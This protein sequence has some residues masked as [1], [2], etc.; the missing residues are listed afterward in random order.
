MLQMIFLVVLVVLLIQSHVRATV[1]SEQLL[2]FKE[3]ESLLLLKLQKVERHSLQLHETISKRLRRAGIIES[4]SEENIE[5]PHPFTTQTTELKSMTEELHEQTE[6][7]QY[8]LQDAAVQ[9]I[10]EEYG[11]GP[12]KVVLEIEFPEGMDSSSHHLKQQ[13]GS[14]SSN[15]D[16]SSHL[17]IVLWPDTPHAGWTWLEQ[18]GRPHSGCKDNIARLQRVLRCHKLPIAAFGNWRF[19]TEEDLQRSG[20]DKSAGGIRVGAI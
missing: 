9:N 14:S 19:F 3:E 17:S 12:V 18:I 7:L 20:I 15:Y 13:S 6:I 10:I 2:Q 1:A 11:E 16:G 5:K 4:D 8:K